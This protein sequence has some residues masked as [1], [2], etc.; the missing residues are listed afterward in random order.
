MF[1]IYHFCGDKNWQNNFRFSGFSNVE[2][3]GLSNQKQFISKT[4]SKTCTS[5]NNYFYDIQNKIIEIEKDIKAIKV[6]EQNKLYEIHEPNEIVNQKA[7]LKKRIG[8]ISYDVIKNGK[9]Q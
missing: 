6:L 1:D 5:I 7:M 9:K 4:L 3:W 2:E 8:T